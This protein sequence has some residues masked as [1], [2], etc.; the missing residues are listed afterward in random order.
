MCILNRRQNSP[1]R[2]FAISSKLFHHTIS[3]SHD[4]GCKPSSTHAMVV[5]LLVSTNLCGHV[6]LT[7]LEF[8]CNIALVLCPPSQSFLF[9]CVLNVI[10]N[11]TELW[12]CSK[13]VN[14]SLSCILTLCFIGISLVIV[15]IF[16]S[17]LSLRKNIN[18]TKKPS[19]FPNT[20]SSISLISSLPFTN[21]IPNIYLYLLFFSSFTQLSQYSLTI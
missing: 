13:S 1:Q 6:F 10:H 15:S 4:G 2:L 14:N 9:C 5:L 12:L 8:I 7:Y 18:K 21:K 17:F 16:E 20:P 19:L 11:L 3:L